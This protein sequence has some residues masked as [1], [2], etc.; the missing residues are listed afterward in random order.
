MS[1]KVFLNGKLLD[2]KTGKLDTTNIVVSNGKIIGIGYVPDEKEGEI[3]QIDIAGKWILPGIT[4][5][6]TMV[7]EPGFSE[8]ETILT[9]TRAAANGGVTQIVP[10]PELSPIIDNT[11]KLTGFMRQFSSETAI[12]AFPMVSA[13]VGEGTEMSELARLRGLGAIA[14]SDMGRTLS[15]E[16]LKNGFH[17]LSMMQMP[18]VSQPIST[19]N[20]GKGVVH[21]G[22]IATVLGLPGISVAQEVTRIS[23][24]G[25]WAAETG[26]QAIILGVSAA[27][28]ID[29]IAQL[30]RQGV[31]ISAGVSIHHCWFTDRQVDGFDVNYKVLP[32]LRTERDQSIL[33]A[34]LA[35]GVIDF[36]YADHRP[37]VLDRKREDFCTSEFGVSSLD[38]F[39]PLVYT[40]LVIEWEFSLELAYRMVST[41]VAE[42]FGLPNPALGIGKDANFTVVDPNSSQQVGLDR[43]YSLGKNTPYLG[44]TLRA[45]PEFTVSK[46]NVWRTR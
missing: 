44:N 6:N 12:T 38:C 1:I 4:D 21:S 15:A 33:K 14:A 25:E 11:E 23:Q 36:I 34:G 45:W 7:G 20:V 29:L 46:G 8:N 30:K 27:R 9:V 3:E 2:P 10:S 32:P 37:W 42:T 41:N 5:V 35:D 39:W 26:G 19:H 18:L 28:S 40:K 43:W 13:I 17:Y 16:F 24:V 22:E 31:R